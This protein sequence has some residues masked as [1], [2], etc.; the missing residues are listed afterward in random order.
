MRNNSVVK[1]E[2]KTRK[3]RRNGETRCCEAPRFLFKTCRLVVMVSFHVQRN[4]PKQFFQIP[5][6]DR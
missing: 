4:K 5:V 6:R 2:G 1:N 3:R